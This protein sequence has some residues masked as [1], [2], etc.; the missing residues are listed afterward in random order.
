MKNHIQFDDLVLMSKAILYTKS[1]EHIWIDYFEFLN[2]VIAQSF[3][4]LEC[5]KEC[6][7]IESVP[8]LV[9]KDEKMD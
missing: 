6:N 2:L 1:G 5:K 9:G 3:T 4:S 7:I 8:S